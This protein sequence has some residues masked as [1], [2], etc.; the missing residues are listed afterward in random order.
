MAEPL[1]APEYYEPPAHGW[2]C[3]HCGETFIHTIAAR[4][5]FG[6]GPDYVPGCVDRLTPEEYKR[7]AALIRLDIAEADIRQAAAR[8]EEA[9]R[10][11][12][13]QTDHAAALRREEETGYARG[14]RD[15]RE[16]CLR[17]IT[18]IKAGLRNGGARNACDAIVGDLNEGCDG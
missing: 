4:C 7:R 12:A 8:A 18:R 3:F 17:I 13:M 15:E 14:L 11:M 16:R 5:H 2:T 10:L 6:L 9:P 1:A